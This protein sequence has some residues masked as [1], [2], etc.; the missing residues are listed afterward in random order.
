M[1]FTAH[2]RA[3]ALSAGRCLRY[4]GL[5][6]LRFPEGL[7]T[8][9]GKLQTAFP[10]ASPSPRPRCPAGPR[11]L[12]A[13]SWLWWPP[14]TGHPGAGR[15][16]PKCPCPGRGGLGHLLNPCPSRPCLHA[17][18]DESLV[19]SECSWVFGVAAFS[20]SWSEFPA[21]SGSPSRSLRRGS[22]P[23][24]SPSGVALSCRAS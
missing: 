17:L 14:C 7:R 19:R 13:V 16:S 24:F 11:G 1:P 10:S 21:R 5:M 20:R 12:P 22:C 2:G 23:R 6:T 4:L 9:F 8:F 15:R 3:F 18:G